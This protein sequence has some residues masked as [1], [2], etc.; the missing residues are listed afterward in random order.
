ME[1]PGR[2]CAAARV[3]FR[4]R[5]G[6]V[7][8]LLLV[9]AWL[10]VGIASGGAGRPAP[11]AAQD[12]VLLAEALPGLEGS[13]LGEVDLGPAPPPGSS[14][15]IRRAEI[16][17]AVRAAGHDPGAL[18][19][20]RVVRVRRRAQRLSGTALV[21]VA[22]E[23]LTRDLAPCEVLAVR[24]SG[25]VTVGAG[26]LRARAEARL[27]ARDGEATVVGA[28]TL[29]SRGHRARVPVRARVRCP[30][31]VVTPG[32]SVRI[33][34][35]VG[36]VRVSAMGEARQAGRVGDVIRVTNAATD[37]TVDARVLDAHTVQVVM[38]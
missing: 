35:I 1:R 4:G 22:R 28:V 3:P 25:P 12:R 13:D 10:L 20:P 33:H 16:E 27:P 6:E 18:R 24:A 17:A 30:G 11:A 23:A 32:A 37:A 9:A 31:P 26:P 34:A 7:A 15:T 2:P 21:R 19:I 8:L 29:V 38:R 5:T 14:R 36:T